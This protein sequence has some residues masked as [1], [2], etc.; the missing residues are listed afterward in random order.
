MVA[1]DDNNAL[2]PRRF[3]RYLLLERI[4]R[5][6]M[7]EVFRARMFGPGG[8]TKECAI[9]KILPSL[10]D[11]EQFV[12]M[13]IDEARVT[14]MLTH[15]NIV[16]VLE[17]GQLDG[18][19]FIAMEFVWG[20]DLLDVLARCARRSRR[21][22]RELVLFT[23]ME[24]LKGLGHAHKA[25]NHTGDAVGIVHRDVSPSNILLSYDG[26]VKVSDF[27]IAKSHIQ[28]DKTEIGTQ[29]GKMGYMSPE[30][31]TGGQ[32]DHRSDLF[33]ASVIF[34]EMLT[35][36][37][38]FKEKNDLDVMLK[39]RDVDI[40]SDL[41]RLRNLPSDLCAIIER[42]LSRDPDDRFQTAEDYHDAIA[43]FVR[44]ADI[45]V[46]ETRLSTFMQQ[47][48][49]DRLTEEKRRRADDPDSAEPFESIVSADEARFRFK[50]A[51][52]RIHGPMK[53]A[54]LD[55]LLRSRPADASERVSDGEGDWSPIGEFRELARIPRPTPTPDPTVANPPPVAAQMAFREDAATRD[56]LE[57]AD[58]ED[59]SLG[60]PD[61]P[62]A[63]ARVRR[64]SRRRRSTPTPIN[65]G[66]VTGRRAQCNPTLRRM[67][68]RFGDPA[69]SGTLDRLSAVRLA[70]DLA[71]RRCT[72]VLRIDDN[73]DERAVYFA[74][75]LPVAVD[76]SVDDELLGAWLASRG[77]VEPGAVQVALRT[78]AE[79]DLR[80]GDA[81]VRLKLLAPHQL[82]HQLSDHIGVK[83]R[84]LLFMRDAEW[85]WWPD[86]T[87]ETE[88][89]PVE[90]TVDGQVIQGVSD[91]RRTSW[92]RSFYRPLARSVL[93]RRLDNEALEGLQLSARG[94]RLVTSIT[95]GMTVADVVHLFADKYRWTEAEV[96]RHLFLVTEFGIFRY[97]GERPLDL[98]G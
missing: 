81:M 74:N 53:L 88:P 27:G 42:G 68:S 92:L 96:Y 10:L 6:G 45:R 62:P 17:L 7:A 49:A 78:S 56:V 51:D 13:F 77:I 28:S 85:Q 36:S 8:F 39:I 46:G 60:R 25:R 61:A 84:A 58:W 67:T 32:I 20:K 64:P 63:A 80:L 47:V 31:V 66:S 55:E 70:H 90:V 1:N 21:I 37:R 76:T 91:R 18:H 29:K 87:T 14:A 48:F 43:D 94:L 82:Y 34:F 72:G 93:E 26:R 75:G 89:L 95:P 19:L 54:M 52:G 79:K 59:L 38:L 41:K 73:A 2:E 9:K 15:S 40:A 35:M 44:R 57:G 71:V 4:G 69:S 83:L 97:E 65:Q 30:Q 3:G 86:A 22:P 24:L 50:D 23:M 33:A 98:P 5:G 12:S 16:Q 11:D